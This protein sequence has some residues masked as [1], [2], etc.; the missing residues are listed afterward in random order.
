LLLAANSSATPANSE[1]LVICGCC[2]VVN[3]VHQ[4][5]GN[6]T[7]QS[8]SCFSH[9]SQPQLLSHNAKVSQTS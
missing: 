4:L 8:T 5:A 6:I 9:K 2:D 7:I 1:A 3:T